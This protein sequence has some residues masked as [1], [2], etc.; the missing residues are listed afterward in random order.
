MYVD[1]S[2]NLK[3]Y[4]FKEPFRTVGY[5]RIHK[6]TKR[7]YGCPSGTI[8]Y[9]TGFIREGFKKRRSNLGYLR[10][11]SNLFQIFSPEEVI[12]LCIY[13]AFTSYLCT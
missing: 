2:H 4:N 9:H 13:Y 10:E 3:T 8:G 11:N 12:M 6:G 5:K 7:V 1:R